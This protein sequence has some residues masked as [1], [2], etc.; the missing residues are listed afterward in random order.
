MG[1]M[2]AK[3]IEALNTQILYKNRTILLDKKI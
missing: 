3:Y 1:L 2:Q